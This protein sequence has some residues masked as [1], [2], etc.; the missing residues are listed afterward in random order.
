MPTERERLWQ[1]CG[2]PGPLPEAVEEGVWYLSL[3]LGAAAWFAGLLLMGVTVVIWNPNGVGDFTALALIWGLAGLLALH[4]GAGGFLAQLGL[5]LLMAGECAAVIALGIRFDAAEPTLLASALLFAGVAS[6][7]ARPAAQILNVL[8][9]AVAGVLWLRWSLLGAPWEDV[10]PALLPALGVWLLCWGPLLA[11][12]VLIVIHEARWM[13]T[14]AA[15]LL[16]AVITAL[17]VVLAV[18]TPLTQPFAGLFMRDSDGSR[19]WMALWP[20]LS[21]CAA[22]IATAVAWQQRQ[23]ILLAL[24]GAGLLIHVAHF[25]YALGVSLIAKSLVMLL[26]GV[27]LLGLA[28]MWGP[29]PGASR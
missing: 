10:R 14:R 25:Y 8:S 2:A 3:M 5:C 16:R 18:A 24:C 26:M 7:A 29:E 13:A 1:L 9:A 20:L 12:L 23:R 6:V 11:A 17:I 22:G 15:G 27:G 19:D 21:L 28:R 4:F